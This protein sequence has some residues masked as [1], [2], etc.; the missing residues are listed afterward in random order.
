M[1]ML[2]SRLVRC[3]FADLLTWLAR[4]TW[5]SCSIDGLDNLPEW[6]SSLRRVIHQQINSIVIRFSPSAHIFHFS[7]RCSKEFHSKDSRS[8]IILQIFFWHF[9]SLCVIDTLLSRVHWM[10]TT[11]WW[12]MDFFTFCE[13]IFTRPEND[14]ISLWWAEK[15]LCNPGWASTIAISSQFD[16]CSHLPAAQCVQLLLHACVDFSHNFNNKIQQFVFV[17][18]LTVQQMVDLNHVPRETRFCNFFLLADLHSWLSELS[19]SAQV[20]RG[21]IDDWEQSCNIEMWWL[22]DSK[23]LKNILVRLQCELSSS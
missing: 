21:K 15:K 3:V 10:G 13:I 7:F 11:R 19:I 22:K 17:W 9:F 1:K 12:D 23:G 18:P 5:S 8:N 6:A 4:R 16:Q 14:G 2:L 20:R